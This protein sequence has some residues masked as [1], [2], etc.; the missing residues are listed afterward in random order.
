M[1]GRTEE[2]VRFM[3]VDAVERLGVHAVANAA[4]GFDM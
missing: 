3:V 4:D 2:S 1:G